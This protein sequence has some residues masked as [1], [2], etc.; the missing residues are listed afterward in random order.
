MC[1]HRKVG[2][3][4]DLCRWRRLDPFHLTSSFLC[5][6][7]GVGLF[8]FLFFIIVVVVVVVVVIIIIIIIIIIIK[9][10]RI[11]SVY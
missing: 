5:G 2:E 8:G 1:P 3:E 10:R 11:W 6:G 9:W 4:M 7:L